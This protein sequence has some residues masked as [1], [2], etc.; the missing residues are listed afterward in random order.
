[1][2]LARSVPLPVLV[3]ACERCMSE[4]CACDPLDCAA[5]LEDGV[6]VVDW[7]VDALWLAA[8]PLGVAVDAL[9]LVVDALGLALEPLVLADVSP[10]AEPLRLPL[11]FVDA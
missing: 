3:L 1:M 9:G 10:E 6:A 7:L 8:E 11:V 2:L 5:A 4:R